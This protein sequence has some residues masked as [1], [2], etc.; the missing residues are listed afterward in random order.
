M[1]QND[2]DVVVADHVESAIADCQRQLGTARPPTRLRALAFL[3]SDDAQQQ[4]QST[5]ATD[6]RVN[7]FMLVAA[8][9]CASCSSVRSR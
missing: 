6:A 9:S 4:Q 1:T 5:P 3:G 8:P 2:T 7:F